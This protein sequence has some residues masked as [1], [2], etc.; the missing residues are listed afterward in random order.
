MDLSLLRDTL[1]PA[2]MAQADR[3]MLDSFKGESA[4]QSCLLMD[5][6]DTSTSC[7]PLRHDTIQIFTES[8]KDG[9][10]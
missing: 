2:N 6:A 1:P 8:F 10:Q 3:E 4:S 5:R 7:R 9:L